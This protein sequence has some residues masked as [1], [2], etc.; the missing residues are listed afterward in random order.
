MLQIPLEHRKA[1]NRRLQFHAGSVDR[2]E[3]LLRVRHLRGEPLAH[4]VEALQLRSGRELLAQAAITS[5][6]LNAL[7]AFSRPSRSS[8]IRVLGSSAASLTPRLSTVSATLVAFA[9]LASAPAIC[10]VN[11]STFISQPRRLRHEAAGPI[12]KHLDLALVGAKLVEKRRGLLVRGV[13][14][15]DLAFQRV[16][17]L[18]MLGEAV[19]LP[20][21]PLGGCFETVQPLLERAER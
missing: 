9:A 16:E 3:F 1:I 17:V 19:E 11:A 2:G 5:L 15:L 7:S 4:H 6:L 18:A 13:N 8:T 10:V 14:C 12:E 20:L 21:G